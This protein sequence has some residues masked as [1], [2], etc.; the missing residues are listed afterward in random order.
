VVLTSGRKIFSV[1][2][3]QDVSL[4]LDAIG[5]IPGMVLF[6]DQDWWKALQPRLENDVLRL[7]ADLKPEWG[8]APSTGTVNVIRTID[9]TGLSACVI[10][11]TT[12]DP[13][14]KQIDI[15][16]ANV[17]PPG[18][19]AGMR[20]RMAAGSPPVYYT[21]SA[22]YWWNDSY[23][24]GGGSTATHGGLNDHA[25]VNAGSGIYSGAYG[26]QSGTFKLYNFRDPAQFP[27]VRMDWDQYDQFG[28][29]AAG[30]GVGTCNHAFAPSEMAIYADTGAF[31]SGQVKVIGYL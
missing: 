12:I 22:D 24:F 1:A 16:L 21:G 7:N 29:P 10:D 28:Y 30:F 23:V 5:Q 20:W 15:Q 6:R 17:I 19:N 2:A 27:R 11:F 4:L 25:E 18:T 14:Y 26:G 3:Y 13:L 9:V 8:P 31:I